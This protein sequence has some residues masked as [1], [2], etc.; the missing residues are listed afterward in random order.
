MAGPTAE[1]LPHY[2]DAPGFV[3]ANADALAA[4]LAVAARGACADTARLVATAH[5]IPD[6]M[7]AVAGPRRATPTRPS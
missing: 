7:A 4:A 6:A 2:F 3:Q 1:K 5:S